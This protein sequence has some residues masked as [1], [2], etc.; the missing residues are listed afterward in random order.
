MFRRL[1]S[2]SGDVLPGVFGPVPCASNRKAMSAFG[3][4]GCRQRV[5]ARLGWSDLVDAQTAVIE[6]DL[7]RIGR[8]KSNV[9][10]EAGPVNP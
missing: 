5:S 7:H 6:R 9:I 8:G 2:F 3:F 10:R 1:G 4:S